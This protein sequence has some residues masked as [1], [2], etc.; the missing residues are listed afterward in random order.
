MVTDCS[1]RGWLPARGFVYRDE[2]I[3]PANWNLVQAYIDRKIFKIK[4]N[5][6]LEKEK[7]KGKE[8]G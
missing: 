6:S 5:L 7:K 2:K 4:V 3:F 8:N 1:A